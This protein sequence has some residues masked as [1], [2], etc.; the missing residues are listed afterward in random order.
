MTNPISLTMD[1]NKAVTATFTL[2][3]VPSADL[4][5]SK[6]LELNFVSGVTFTIVVRNLGP[7]PANGAVVSDTIPANVTGVTWICS[8]S[9][10]AVCTASGIGNIQDS[11]TLFPSGGVVTYTVWGALHAWKYVQN[12]ATVS[13]PSGVTDPAPGNNS[14]SV[15]SYQIL[16]PL[17]YKH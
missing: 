6:A 7:D 15:H 1:G 10:G 3:A 11:V 16:L 14:A 5:I 13:P 2:S 9:G 8:A 12:T 17:I 4:S